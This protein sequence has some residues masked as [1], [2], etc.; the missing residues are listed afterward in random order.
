MQK[1]ITDILT[2]IAVSL[3]VILTFIRIY[4]YFKEKN[5]VKVKVKG[6]YNLFDTATKNET[7]PY[8]VIAVTNI[9]RFPVTIKS[10][11]LLKPRTKY[12]LFK[13]A[14]TNKKLNTSDSVDY[15]TKEDDIRKIIKPD[16]H[17]AFARSSSGK[18]YYSHNF[19]SRFI[20]LRRIK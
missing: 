11:G 1:Y 12:V 10:A 16:K 20:K 4:D 9:G 6:N 19:I 13:N 5:N 3:S 17:V 14:L 15:L 7:G 18:N 2:I 8:V